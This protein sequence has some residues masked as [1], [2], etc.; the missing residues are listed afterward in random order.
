MSTCTAGPIQSSEEVKKG[1][2]LMH[3]NISKMNDKGMVPDSFQWY[4]VTG[5]GGVCIN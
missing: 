3:I 1:I 2:S 4:P 5:Q